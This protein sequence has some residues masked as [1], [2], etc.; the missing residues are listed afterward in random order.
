MSVIAAV[1]LTGFKLLI[2]ILTGS[3]GLLSEALH[4]GLDLIASMK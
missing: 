1:F 3:L 2:G 4:S